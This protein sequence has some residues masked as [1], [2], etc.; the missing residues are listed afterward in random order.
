MPTSAYV[1]YIHHINTHANNFLKMFKLLAAC[2]SL[3]LPNWNITTNV[4]NNWES[5]RGCD[6][7]QYH[8]KF[9]GTHSRM[10]HT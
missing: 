8:R 5:K 7:S 4:R 6:T 10:K 1:P 2:F 3:T 9:H